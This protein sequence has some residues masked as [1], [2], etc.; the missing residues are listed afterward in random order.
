MGCLLAGNPAAARPEP[1]MLAL[2]LGGGLALRSMPG[3]AGGSIAALML[4]AACFTHAQGAWF[5]AAALV[6]LL[7]EDR[8]RLVA[9][10]LG[11]AVF[12]A[13]GYLLLSRFLGPWF[14]SPGTFRGLAAIRRPRLVPWAPLLGTLG[15]RYDGASV[16]PTRP[17]RPTAAHRAVAASLLATQAHPRRGARHL[18]GGMALVGHLDASGDQHLAWPDPTPCRRGAVLVALVLSSSLF[19]DIPGALP[20]GLAPSTAALGPAWPGASSPPA[21]QWHGRQIVPAS[22]PRCRQPAPSESETS[23]G[24]TT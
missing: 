1:L 9:F 23:E 4:S 8:G 21:V 19:A 15:C 17:G 2:A 13:G 5:A 11:L 6:Y 24:D 7:R 3:A 10:T 14:N 18:R 12:L 22:S 20:A 16:L